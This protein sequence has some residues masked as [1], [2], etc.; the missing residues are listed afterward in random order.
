MAVTA[1]VDYDRY[2]AVFQDTVRRLEEKADTASLSGPTA[3]VRV[4]EDRLC[5]ARVGE[6]S[7]LVDEPVSRGGSGRAPSAMEYFVAGA[8][9][10]L[11]SQIT[12]WSSFLDVPF[13]SLSV[14]GQIIWDQRYKHVIGGLSNAIRGFVFRVTLESDAP[15]EKVIETF[16]KSENGC[17]AS[18]A[19]RSSVPMR[20]QLTV[21]GPKMWTL[22]R[23]SRALQAAS[24]PGSGRRYSGGNRSFAAPA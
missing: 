16:R 23:G 10:C 17:Y 24:C 2:K 21:N 15:R 18:D 11:T 12:G 7:F 3:T 19:I 9:A 20:A 5:E 13:T 8:A 6:R 1:R 4:L 22:V 14:E